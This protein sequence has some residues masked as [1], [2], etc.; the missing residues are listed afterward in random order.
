MPSSYYPHSYV[1]YIIFPSLSQNSWDPL[2]V[3]KKLVITKGYGVGASTMEGQNAFALT[4]FAS[5]TWWMVK[6][7]VIR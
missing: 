2:F 7:R 1:P 4:L 5:F 3:I 6:A